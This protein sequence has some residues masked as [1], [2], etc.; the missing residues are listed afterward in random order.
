MSDFASKPGRSR[1]SDSKCFEAKPLGQQLLMGI[2][3][4][5]SPQQSLAF[6]GPESRY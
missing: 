6:K 4:R 1:I 3:K 5:L 2:P